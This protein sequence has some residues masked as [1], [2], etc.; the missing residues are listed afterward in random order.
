MLPQEILAQVRRLEIVTGKLVAE[1]FS[2]DYLSVFKGRGMEFA[3]VRE[4]TPG[5]DPRDIDRNVSARHGKPFVRRYV[6]ERELPVVVAVDLSASQNFGTAERLKRDAAVEV[7]VPSPRFREAMAKI[8]PLGEVTHRS[9]AATDVSDEFHD[10]EV[11]LQNLRAT[12]TRL[13]ALLT[14]TGTLADTLAVASLIGFEHW[15]RPP[16]TIRLLVIRTT[17]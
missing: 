5:D 4:Y 17:S 3:D 7:R 15:M 14:H 16:V 9:V 2:G 12:R 11:R 10:G 13:E 8:E 6:E 1:S